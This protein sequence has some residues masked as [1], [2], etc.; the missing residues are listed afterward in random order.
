M[1][2]KLRFDPNLDFQ[3]EAI[4]SVVDLFDGLPQRTI[5]FKLGSEVVP[6]IPIYESLSPDWL[7]TNLL[8]VQNKSD[9]EGNLIELTLTSL[10]ASGD[11]ILTEKAILF[12]F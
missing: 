5:D 1:P 6:N 3:L 9:S 2:L 7:Y 12:C 11:C 4:R 10:S 8:S